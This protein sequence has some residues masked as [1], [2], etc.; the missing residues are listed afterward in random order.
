MRGLWPGDRRATMRGMNKPKK[1]ATSIKNIRI[2]PEAHDLGQQAA[3]LAKESLSAFASRAMIEV[4]SRELAAFVAGF[5][6][7]GGGR[8]PPGKRR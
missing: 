3:G 7:E 8:G 5:R 4:A 1:R 6:P 2:S